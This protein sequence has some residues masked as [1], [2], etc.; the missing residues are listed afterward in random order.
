[1]TC[2]EHALSLAEPE[3]YVRVFVDEGPAMKEML[4]RAASRGI[5]PQYV[6]RL[7]AAFGDAT[8]EERQKVER[9]PSSSVLGPP[10]LVDP[11]TARELEVLRLLTTHLSSTEIA[12][13]LFIS[14]NT[15]RSHVRSIYSKL[16]VHSRYQ[17]IG[18][19]KD[20]NLL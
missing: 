16:D 14:V 3:G 15:V 8:M 4:R 19:A 6:A 2:L 20:L 10:S 11:L 5:A 1:M 7:L 18:R 17:A 13:E 12:K 9:S